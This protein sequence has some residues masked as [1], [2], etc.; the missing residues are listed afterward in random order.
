MS[1]QSNVTL[2]KGLGALIPNKSTPAPK[3]TSIPP[4]PRHDAVRTEVA[5]QAVLQLKPGEI[6][7]NPHQPRK[8]FEKKGFAGLV[9]SV[10]KHGIL[11]PLVVMESGKGYELIAGERRLRAAREAKLP[12]VPAL[13]RNAS[14]LEQ[15][16]L[17]LIENLQRDDLDP[18]ERAESYK[19]LVDTFGLTHEEAAKRLA[20]SRPVVSN[21]MRYLSLASAIQKALAEGV[22]SEGQA[23][24][25]LELKSP[26]AQKSLFDQ[27]VEQGLTV[28]ETKHAVEKVRVQSHTRVKTNQ[29][30]LYDQAAKIL[31]SV[32]GTKVRVKKKGKGGVVTVEFY[33]EEELTEIINTLRG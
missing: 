3:Q 7:A 20:V 26:S 30:T 14:E 2:G 17:A 4:A 16:E 9:A 32:L 19:K 23:K 6:R 25:L 29:P 13:V 12:T 33:S 22:I 10:K 11:Q 18:I 8:R 5:T 28:E 27:I 24:V 15:F 31:S 21:T 1:T